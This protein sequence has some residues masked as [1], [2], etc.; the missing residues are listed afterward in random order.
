M[1]NIGDIFNRIGVIADDL[2]SAADGASPFL[3]RGHKPCIYR[4]A[5]TG[6]DAAVVSVDTGSRSMTETNAADATRRAVSA[7]DRDR[8][9]YKTVDSTLRGHVRAEI[10]A[11]FQASRRMRLVVAPAF[12][13]AGRT[14]AGA[15]QLLDGRPVADT[16]Y[17]QDPIH[18]AH[19]SCIRDL[20]DPALGVPALL[21]VEM[22]DAEVRAAA[23]STRVVIV[24]ADSQEKLNQR[25]ACLAQMEP[26]L[27][28]GSPGMALALASLT[29]HATFTG[30]ETP[31]S[32]IRR[33]LIVVG[34]ANR[35]S[36]EQCRALG[37]G[38]V[39]IASRASDITEQAQIACLQAPV[40]RE[41]DAGRVLPRLI[42]EANAA[43]RRQR[44]DAVI[45]SGGETMDALLQRLSIKS[46]NL[47][48][49]L[50][51]GFPAGYAMREPEQP[52]VIA[53]KA[54]G[55]GTPATLLNAARQL[56]NGSRP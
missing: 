37:A 16:G 48:G 27:W 43:L 44:F 52:L 33:V 11:A 17:A 39:A 36:H 40:S 5:A 26:A 18:P 28:V 8:T 49:E 53:L 42:D 35:T 6:D 14:T 51:P 31:A 19:T 47:T 10:L 20:V 56:S 13:A 24:D 3:T 55:F 41:T 32:P 4:R 54:G 7:F 29:A 25:V 2:T 50:E 15:I 12:P 23:A 9:L 45:A 38:G 34:S 21:T 1:E 46:F 30:P 22:S